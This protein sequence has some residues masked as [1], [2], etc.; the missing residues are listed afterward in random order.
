MISFYN[1]YGIEIEGFGESDKENLFPSK[2]INKDTRYVEIDGKILDMCNYDSFTE[3]KNFYKRI[4]GR[5][6]KSIILD[7]LTFSDMRSVFS[8]DERIEISEG[9]WS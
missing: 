4:G 5:I 1:E 2:G 6:H 8:L 3:I 7:F 9:F